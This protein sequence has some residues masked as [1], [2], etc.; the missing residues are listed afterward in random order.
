MKR[1]ENLNQFKKE[2]KHFFNLY[3]YDLINRDEF[4]YLVSNST[5]KFIDSEINR[6]CIIISNKFLK[7]LDKKEI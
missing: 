6:Y 4:S 1:S 5:G 2:T 3:N 7:A